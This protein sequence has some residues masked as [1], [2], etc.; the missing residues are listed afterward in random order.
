M[1]YDGDLVSYGYP[2]GLL[3]AAK[4]LVYDNGGTKIYR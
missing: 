3:Q 2:A 1:F 4:D